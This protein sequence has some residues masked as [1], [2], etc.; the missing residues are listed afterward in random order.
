MAHLVQVPVRLVRLR[1]ARL[2]PRERAVHQR[3]ERVEEHKQGDDDGNLSARRL[4]ES[5]AWRQASNSTTHLNPEIL[6]QY[7]ST[8]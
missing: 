8:E 5:E 6:L 7:S 2:E 3:G 1:V 4:A